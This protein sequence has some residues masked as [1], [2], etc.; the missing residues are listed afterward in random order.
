MTLNIAIVD[1]N[2]GAREDL[3]ALVRMSPGHHLVSVCK[4]GRS[5]LIELP[6]T[7]PAVILI[8]ME[9]RDLPGPDCIRRLRKLL[10]EAEFIVFAARLELPR[11]VAAMA[12]GAHGY[13]LRDST[14]QRVLEAIREIAAGGAPLAPAVARC[15]VEQLHTDHPGASETARLSQREQQVLWRLSDGLRIKEVAAV[16]NIS[17][18]TVQTHVRNIYQKMGVS[19]VAQAVARCF[20]SERRPTGPTDL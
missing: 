16:L 19:T 8:E 17:T 11:I 12:A 14:P 5:A 6:R 20:R 13:L 9:L 18:Y 4:T 2:C 1:D 10:P 3:A 7:R 15:L